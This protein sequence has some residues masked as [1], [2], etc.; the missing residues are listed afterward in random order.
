M[1][2]FVSELEPPEAD[3]ALGILK[4]GTDTG[5]VRDRR[6]RV[7]TLLCI[8]QLLGLAGVVGVTHAV[9]GLEGGDVADLVPG[10]GF[11]GGGVDAGVDLGEGDGV[12]A[13]VVG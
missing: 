12:D 9:E 7:S 2:P 4:A 5:L 8:M 11:D 10:A 3:H 13:C 6:R 1:Q